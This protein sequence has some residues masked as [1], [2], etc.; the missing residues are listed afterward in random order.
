MAITVTYVSG[1]TE[2]LGCGDYWPVG[3]NVSG[4]GPLFPPQGHS[5]TFSLTA[6]DCAI[7]GLT[8]PVKL[9][10]HVSNIGGQFYTLTNSAGTPTAPNCSFGGGQNDCPTCVNGFPPGPTGKCPKGTHLVNGVCVKNL[11]CAG[12]CPAGFICQ[13]GQCVPGLKCDGN[14]LCPGGQVCQGGVCTPK[15]CGPGGTPC[16]D[17]QQCVNGSCVPNPECGSGG[18]CNSGQHCEGGKCVPDPPCG[19]DSQCPDGTK[20]TNGTCRPTQCDPSSP[21]YASCC[22][23]NP[24]DAGCTPSCDPNSADYA[25][26]CTAHPNDPNCKASCSPGDPNY[27]QCCLNDPRNPNYPNCSQTCNCQSENWPACCQNDPTNPRYPTCTCTG[28][29]GCDCHSPNYP[30]CC[31]NDPSNPNYPDCLPCDNC[32]TCNPCQRLDTIIGLMQQGTN[33]TP[34]GTEP[35]VSLREAPTVAPP[36]LSVSGVPQSSDLSS[37]GS[38]APLSFTLPMPGRSPLSFQVGSKASDWKF[39]GSAPSAFS[40]V[41]AIV[42][43]FRVGLRLVLVFILTWRFV[44]SLVDLLFKV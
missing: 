44:K 37:V 2:T 41:A 26:C 34:T 38:A 32:A 17:G 29:Q 1:E 3:C 30:A 4:C 36:A 7:R 40:G 11:P 15:G 22:G 16:P 5:F 10:G 35:T 27:P 13:A 18:L 12:G 20:C 21:D 33:A 25:S 8:G 19:E 31:K 6:P 24:N 39:G 43:D 14:H 23:R 9:F 28:P 42:D